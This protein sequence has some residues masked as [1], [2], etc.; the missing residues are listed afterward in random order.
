[1]IGQILP[2]SIGGGPSDVGPQVGGAGRQDLIGDTSEQVDHPCPDQASDGR[3]GEGRVDEA[4]QYQGDEDLQAN[5][6]KKRS[7]QYAHPTG[8]RPQVARKC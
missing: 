4:T 1:M 5:R 7:T 8:L 6:G 2:E 3:P